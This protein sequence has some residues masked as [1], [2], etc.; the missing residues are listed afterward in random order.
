MV[1]FILVCRLNDEIS[2]KFDEF[3]CYKVI[4]FLMKD[5]KIKIR[6]IIYYFDN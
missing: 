1:W 6:F 3:I 4:N 5:F 2:V